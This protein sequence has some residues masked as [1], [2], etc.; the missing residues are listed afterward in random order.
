MIYLEGN[1]TGIK[2]LMKTLGLCE[3]NLRL[4]LVQASKHLTI[5]LIDELKKLVSVQTTQS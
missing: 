2:V 3:N 4:P 1:P 5:Q